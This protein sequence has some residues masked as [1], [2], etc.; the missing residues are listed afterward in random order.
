MEFP[1][2]S[3]VYC[4]RLRPRVDVDMDFPC[5]LLFSR[6]LVA[7]VVTRFFAAAWINGRDIVCSRELD[8][9]VFFKS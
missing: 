1:K 6:D 7:S 2:E 8:G 9:S 5:L 3:P 4:P